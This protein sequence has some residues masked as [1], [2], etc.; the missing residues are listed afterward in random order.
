[1]TNLVQ[2]EGGCKLK[3]LKLAHI[4]LKSSTTQASSTR[5]EYSKEI[6]EKGI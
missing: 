2:N 4:W 3:W 5:Q 6:K 1:M